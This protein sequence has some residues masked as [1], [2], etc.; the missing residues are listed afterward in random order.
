MHS[1]EK[2][3]TKAIN[4]AKILIQSESDFAANFFS[5]WLSYLRNVLV[6]SIICTIIDSD[7]YAEI[8]IIV[9][10]IL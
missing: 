10:C 8:S 9:L 6:H 4:H 5:S 7:I 2:S 1:V 3:A